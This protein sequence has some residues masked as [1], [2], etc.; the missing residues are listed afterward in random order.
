MTEE[1]KSS[2]W[3]TVNESWQPK[4][5]AEPAKHGEEIRPVEKDHIKEYAEKLDVKEPCTEDVIRKDD[6]YEGQL[7][8]LCPVYA[9]K[10][11]H[12]A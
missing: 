4:E 8:C 12:Q 2:G 5:L 9:V 3:T 10:Q 6:P 1:Y 11:E 7:E